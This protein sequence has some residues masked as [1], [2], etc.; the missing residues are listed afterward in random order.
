MSNEDGARE[1]CSIVKSPGFQ[2]TVQDDRLDR[3]F[4]LE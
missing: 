2:L 3:I 4:D 1:C